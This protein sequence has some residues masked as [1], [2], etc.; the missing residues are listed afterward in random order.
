MSYFSIGNMIGL[1][2][3]CEDKSGEYR[4]ENVKK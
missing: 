2:V 4:Y 3:C 1:L